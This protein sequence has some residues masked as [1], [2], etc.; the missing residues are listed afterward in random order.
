MTRVA[1]YARYSSDNQRDASIEDQLRLC[2]DYAARQSWTIVE[3]YADRAVSGDS[4]LR[5]GIQAVIAD[6]QQSRFDVVLTEA[7]DRISRD[8][9]D[10]AAV[11]KRLRFAGVTIMTLAEGEIC[12]LHIGLKGT[13]NALFLKDLA[14]K[15]HRGIRGRVEKGKYS[16]GNCY[17]YRVVK[18]LD[19]GG[20]PIRG[21]REI[22]PDEAE[23]IRRIFR[24]YAAGLSPPRIVS[25]L[26]QKRHSRPG[27]RAVGGILIARQ[28]AARNWHPQQRALRRPNGLEPPAAD[29]E[30]AHR[31]AGAAYQSPIR[32]GQGRCTKTPHHR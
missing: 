28:S 3:S 31:R 27:R 32:M 26:K 24:D 9:E 20:E 2:R 30:P 11:F 29:E 8:Q 5:A 1:L 4:L 25:A 7:L 22:V 13:M 10:V 14:A 12:E 6:A 15:T 17:G 18:R 16:G 23:I 21:E 19:P